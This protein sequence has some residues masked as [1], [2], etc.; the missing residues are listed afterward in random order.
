MPFDTSGNIFISH[1]KI[2]LFSS[3]CYSWP[4]IGKIRQSRGGCA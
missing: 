1:I 4:S 2:T 3:V